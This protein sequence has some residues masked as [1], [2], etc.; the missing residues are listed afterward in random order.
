MSKAFVREIDELIRAKFTTIQVVTWEE[1]RALS[2]LTEVARMQQKELFQWS[3]TDG[4][5]RVAGPRGH[6]GGIPGERHRDAMRMLNEILQSS[7]SAIYVLLDFDDYLES[8][9]VAR[10]LRDLHQALKSTRKSVVIISSSSK[11]ADKLSKTLTLV[12]LPL[13][14]YEEL[15]ALLTERI[16]GSGESRTFQV[17]LS[18][19]EIDALA[20]EAQGLTMAEAESAFAKAIV[21]DNKLCRTD[22]AAILEQKKQIIR[23]AGLLE[24]CDVSERLR[25]VGGMELLKEWLGKRVRA[26]EDEARDYGLPAPRG[27]LV[28]GVQGCGKSLIAKC[29][30]SEWQFPLLRMDMSRIFHGYVGGSE[31]N[32]R[33]ALQ[34][35]ES[36]APVVLW[37]DEVEKALSGIDGSSSS[38][39]GTTARVIGQLLTWMQEKQRPVFVVATAN[40]V[41]QL[42]PELLRKGRL[43]E[44][45]FVD[46]PNARERAEIFRIHLRS[47]KRDPKLFDL[48]AL[49]EA[50]E[51]F[52]GAEIEQALVSALHDSFFDR[53]EVGTSDILHSLSVTVPLSQTMREKIS[54]LREWAVQRACPVTQRGA[55]KPAGDAA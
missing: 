19:K 41:E 10:Q 17:Q 3:V 50:S 11:A 32:M 9:E 24:Y 31:D 26:F 49:A 4:L 6:E 27:M 40:S 15:R 55:A 37:I 30:A 12:D 25:D 13:P 16:I 36:L 18:D 43:D 51:G 29:V 54:A 46:L 5:R 48:A 44:V 14:T 21:R 2:L 42:P 8:P 28:M 45:F 35:A 22:I 23:R 33:R 52:S 53:R 7:A 47:R 34:L 39:A 38:D 20:K 1:R